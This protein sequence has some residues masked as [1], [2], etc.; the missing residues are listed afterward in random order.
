MKFKN[1]ELWEKGVVINE[2][3]YGS[4][5]Y[6]Y[7]KRWAELMESKM[8]AGETLEQVAKTASREADTEGITG[9]QYG[10]A[11]GILAQCWEH[12]EALRRWHNLDV[13]IRDEG[14]RAN[15]S[16]GV[17]NPAILSIG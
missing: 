8:A 3:P 4:C 10:C 17:I 14:E 7:A 5:V 2:D 9:F 12:G 6:R 11:V 16:G 1:V 13:Q 15:I